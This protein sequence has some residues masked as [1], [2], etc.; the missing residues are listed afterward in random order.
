MNDKP[1]PVLQALVLADMIY[2]DALGKRLICGTFSHIW[3]GRFPTMLNRPTWAYI[4]L[5]EVV[6]RPVMQ[7]RFVKLNDN[8]ILMKSPKIEIGGA[9]PLVPVDIAIEIP[10]L[11]LP[12]SGAYGVECLVDDILIGCMRLQVDKAETKD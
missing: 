11:P 8:R 3:C 6:G 5:A 12:S 9:S 1:P 4:L 7:L 2:T 10:P